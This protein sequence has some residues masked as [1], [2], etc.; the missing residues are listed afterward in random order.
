MTRSRRRKL[1]RLN[2]RRPS[3][4][5]LKGGSLASM[6]LAGLPAYAQD[7]N[8]QLE[9]VVVSAQKRDE[10]LQSVPLSIT[11]LG[12]VKLEQMQVKEF[13]DYAKFL[14]SVSYQS[15]GPG[16]T[17]VYMRGLASGENANH[18]GPLPQVGIYLDEQPITTIQG[19]LDVHVYDIARVEA[20][21]GPQGTLY[22]ASSQAGTIRIITN[23]PD[24]SAFKAS[25][26]FT[27]S[28]VSGGDQGYLGEG[29]VNIPL[30]DSAAVRIVGWDRKDPGYIDNVARTITY[31][32][33]QAFDE[34]GLPGSQPARD[35]KV[36][37][38]NRVADNYNDVS[39]YGAR[40]ALRVNLNDNWSI[41][42]GIMGQK[43]NSNGSFG[44][45][46]RLGKLKVGHFKPEYQDDTWW[47]AAMTVEGKIGNLDLTY[48][49]SHLKRDI[50]SSSDYT[51]Y[52]YFYDVNYGYGAYIY[53]ANG[54]II[55]STQ[56]FEGIDRFTKDS[57]ELRGGGLLAAPGARHPAA[58][59]DRRAGSGHQCARVDQHD[60]AHRAGARRRGQGPVR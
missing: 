55:D 46:P 18:S 34:A 32:T 26:D 31:P 37:N 4:L 39:T 54:D 35:G 14:P 44:T 9:E 53:N 33:L 56:Y 48:A 15:L 13:S 45:D 6:L 24:P 21:A 58:L 51:D 8:G 2:A 43:Q 7:D 47:Q 1:E 30:G 19:A 3:H 23:K 27:G 25:Y 41:T 50:H 38:A 20:L 52:S 22:G 17:A 11:A 29:F 28:T 16:S 59:Q 42:P 5:L 60:L 57:Q 36:S 10:N 40:A 49:G 12:T